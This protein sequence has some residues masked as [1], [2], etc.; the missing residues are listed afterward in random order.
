MANTVLTHQMIAREAAPM[1]EEELP[2]LK[3][4]NRSREKAIGRDVEGYSE[5]ATVKVKIPPASQVF[6]GAIFAGGGTAPDQKETYANLTV[7]TR[8]DGLVR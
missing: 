4:I 7:N 1:L 8:T 2:F 3:G 5:G 6:N